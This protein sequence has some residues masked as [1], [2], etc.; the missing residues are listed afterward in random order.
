MTKRVTLQE[1]TV[2]AQ[3]FYGI[4]TTLYMKN[5]YFLVV[6]NITTYTEKEITRKF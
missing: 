5:D 1:H 3:L 6:K 2:F 4:S